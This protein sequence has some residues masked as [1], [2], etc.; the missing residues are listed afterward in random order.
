MKELR[1]EQRILVGKSEAMKWPKNHDKVGKEEAAYDSTDG[2]HL[3]Q[4]RIVTWAGQEISQSL[5]HC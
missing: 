2:I 5:R 4:E 1:G 3:T